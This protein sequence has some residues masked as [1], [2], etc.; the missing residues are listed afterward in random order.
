MPSSPDIS[1]EEWQAIFNE[2][3]VLTIRA[4]YS[5]WDRH[6]TAAM[7]DNFDLSIRDR[8][9][10]YYFD[11]LGHLKLGTRSF[12]EGLVYSIDKLVNSTEPE[13]RL[14]VAVEANERGHEAFV[15][16]L[17]GPSTDQLI[18]DL[19]WFGEILSGDYDPTLIFPDEYG[20]DNDN[21]DD[22]NNDGG[23]NP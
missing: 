10:M 9:K 19:E 4:G 21:D 13:K 15:P 23:M 5:D 20:D 6:A 14:T 11:L 18:E 1:P 3:R 22:N 2:L 17:A 8:V 16:F 12:R 7:M